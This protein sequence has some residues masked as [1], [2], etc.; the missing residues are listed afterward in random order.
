MG[1]KDKGTHSLL[2]E[3]EKKP[4]CRHAGSAGLR[5]FTEPT[6][7]LGEAWT[8]EWKLCDQNAARTFGHQYARPRLEETLDWSPNGSHANP[9]PTR[10][11]H[12]E[13]ECSANVPRRSACLLKLRWEFAG[14][15]A[16][17]EDRLS[18]PSTVFMNLHG[19]KKKR[20]SFRSL[21]AHIMRGQTLWE[22]KKRDREKERVQEPDSRCCHPKACPNNKTLELR[23]IIHFFWRTDLCNELHFILRNVEGSHKKARAL[24]FALLN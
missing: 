4:V 5:R 13:C 11:T 14:L 3:R 12:T 23:T 10:S 21:C 1:E 6:L 18:V 22:S 24:L 9:R 7:V 2:Q 19:L 8:A 17:S 15:W 16:W 20:D